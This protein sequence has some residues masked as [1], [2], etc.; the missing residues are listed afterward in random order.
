MPAD[1]SQRPTALIPW[2]GRLPGGV[3]AACTVDE[4][5]T[6]D[7]SGCQTCSKDGSKCT[8]CWDN[9]ALSD[10]NCIKVRGHQAARAGGST[11]LRALVPLSALPHLGKACAMLTSKAPVQV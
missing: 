5:V 1:P 2:L 8:Q 3:H 7:G 10:G 9:Y 11:A 6:D 4:Y